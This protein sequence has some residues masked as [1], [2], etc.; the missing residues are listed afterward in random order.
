MWYGI[1]LHWAA[2]KG[3]IGCVKV[4]AEWPSTNLSLRND[5]GEYAYQMTSNDTINVLLQGVWYYSAGIEGC[6]AVMLCTIKF[7]DPLGVHQ[8]Q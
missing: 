8:R 7:I 2:E 6:V 3:E 5:R 1:A 4:L